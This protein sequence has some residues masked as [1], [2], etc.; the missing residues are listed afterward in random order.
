[1]RNLAILLTATTL[2][3]CG[4]GAQSVSGTAVSAGV[5]GGTQTGSAGST[6]VYAQF[7]TPTVSK[8]YSGIGA[9]QVYVYSTDERTPTNNN[10]GQGLIGSRGQQAVI[11]AGNASSVRDSKIQIT[12]DPRDAIFTLR[13][14]DPRSGA[15]ANTRF[16]DP[17]SRTNFGGAIEPQWGV[18][19]F[20]DFPG[21]GQNNNIR[22]LQAGDGD[23]R[24]PYT[25]GGVGA[26]SPGSNTLRPTG[27]PGSTYQSTTMFYEVPGASTSYVS[28]AGYVRNAF[29]WVDVNGILQ[30]QHQLE[31]GAFAYGI[32]SDNATV[33]ITG[34]GTYTGNM[35]G[36]VVFNPTLDT[37]PNYPT[38]FQWMSGTSST[39]VSFATGAVALRLDGVVGAPKYDLN[40]TPHLAALAAGA[41][42]T[43]SGTATVN[44]INTGGFTGQMQSAAFSATTNGSSPTIVIAG[45]SIDGVFYG[46]AANE[47]GGGFRITGGT[48]DQRID[49]VGAFKGKKP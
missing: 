34:S 48:P 24:S 3:A 17:A 11:Y 37:N 45:S 30:T 23:P 35:I 27:D 15:E 44:L 46:P 10:L 2:A 43:A 22:F 21:I 39:T 13:V 26:V 18:D 31:R 9:S 14:T 5:G 41:T 28:L 42:F 38:F 16:Q 20:A 1:M 33:P 40:T 8:T 29:K 49:I 4:G 6:N 19:N 7:V 47:L 12:Y 25:R 32:V 36:S